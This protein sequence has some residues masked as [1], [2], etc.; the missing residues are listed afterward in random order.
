MSETN[1]NFEDLKRLLE[2]KRR[3]IP[4]PGYFHHFSGDVVARIRTGESGGAQSFLERLH[5]D[6]PYLTALLQLVG[7]KPGIVGA[8]ASGAC[9]LLLVGVLFTNRSEPGST[10]APMVF[11]QSATEAS[12]TLA[13]SDTLEP[14]DNGITVSTNPVSSLQ[15]A[16]TLFGAPQNPLFQ[17]AGFTPASQ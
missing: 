15:P 9:L 16:N 1:N 7:A 11:A 17:S 6:S 13:S 8:L 5:A 3:E 4:P 12:P 14:A 10:A 2:L